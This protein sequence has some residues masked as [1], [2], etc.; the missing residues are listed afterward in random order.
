MNGSP[1][2]SRAGL[3]LAFKVVISIVL[4]G[5]LFQRVSWDQVRVTLG[6]ARLEWLVAAFALLVASNVLG[7]YQWNRLLRVVSIELPFWKVVAYYHVGLFWNNFLPANVGGDLARI[8]DASRAGSTRT[9]AFS[10]VLLDRMIGTVALGSLAVITTLP[11][12]DHFHLAAVYAGVLG[13]F[14][15]ASGLLWAALHPAA[16]TWLARML[17]SVGLA[18]LR[19]ALEDLRLRMAAFRDQ[20]VLL[21]QLMVVALAVQVMR[22]VVHVLVARALGLH[23]P[24]TY[25]FLFVPLLAVIVSL[26][27]SL[28]GIGVREGAGI[29]LFGLVGLDRESAFLLQFTT[30]LVAVA[31]SL[32]G[33]LVF[34]ARIPRRRADARPSRRSAE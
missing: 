30:Y 13:F 15:L 22:I 34:L 16:M 2:S 5:W 17:V 11:V 9:T 1:R 8:A 24:L 23:I 12:I 4:F 25:F 27:I 20:K 19:P 31:V 10:T 29:V 6:H 33:G 26:P 3:L 18:R 21:A 14:L 32:I 7:S 28:N